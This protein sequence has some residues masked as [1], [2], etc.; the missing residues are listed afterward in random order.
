MQSYSR[1]LI[2]KWVNP[3][4]TVTWKLTAQKFES[5]EHFNST[6]ISKI[7]QVYSLRVW[8]WLASDCSEI[9]WASKITWEND[10]FYFVYK[11]WPMIMMR[12]L[13]TKGAWS[14][15]PKFRRWKSIYKT[16]ATYYYELPTSC[17][18]PAE[19]LREI[20]SADNVLASF[21]KCY[22]LHTRVIMMQWNLILRH[23]Y[24]YYFFKY[25]PEYHWCV[26][27]ILVIS[28]LVSYLHFSS[29]SLVA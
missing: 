1:T 19:V 27:Q 16:T 7:C 11:S 29:N 6:C 20:L 17:P 13:L 4:I 28:M 15:Q 24:L 21:Q 3:F 8:F 10:F 22:L 5:I 12:W 23:I 26:R 9:N 14:E 18:G 25:I 2:Y